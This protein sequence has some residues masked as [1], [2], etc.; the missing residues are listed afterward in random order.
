MNR[1]RRDQLK[2][3]YFWMGALLLLYLILRFI[4]IFQHLQ[5]EFF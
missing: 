1:F 3:V 4:P 2:F 5:V